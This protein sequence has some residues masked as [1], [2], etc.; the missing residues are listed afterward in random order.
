MQPLSWP[1]RL[2][3]LALVAMAVTAQDDDDVDKLRECKV[4]FFNV[5]HTPLPILK[6]FTERMQPPLQGPRHHGRLRQGRLRPLVH[7]RD[8]GLLRPLHVLSGAGLRRVWSRAGLGRGRPAT[9]GP[10]CR[11]LDIQA[12]DAELSCAV[13][14]NGRNVHADVL[15][16]LV[17]TR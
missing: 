10:L 8:T 1:S 12:G 4:S 13:L 2:V 14:D 6:N 5:P 16:D 17:L 3:L 9:R 11:G 7:V 15:E